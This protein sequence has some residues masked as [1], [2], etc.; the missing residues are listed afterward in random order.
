MTRGWGGKS[1]PPLTDVHAR[2]KVAGLKGVIPGFQVLPEGRPLGTVLRDRRV[3]HAEREHL[4]LKAR[5]AGLERR[6]DQ[7]PNFVDDGIR[8][9]V[10]PNG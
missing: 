9:R 1:I 5:L 7:L 6:R 8:H 10:A 3:G 2:G 4:H